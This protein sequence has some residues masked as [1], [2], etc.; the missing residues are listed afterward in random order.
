VLPVS[1]IAVCGY[2]KFVFDKARSPASMAYTIS[3]YDEGGRPLG[4]LGPYATIIEA[5]NAMIKHAGRE[6]DVGP[7]TESWVI[8]GT[9]Y[10]IETV[11]DPPN[12]CT[13][14][15]CTSLRQRAAM[16][17]DVDKLLLIKAADEIER[18]QACKQA[19]DD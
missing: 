17:T 19:K 9:E 14:R 6:P 2:A 3:V 18:L 7:F 11:D 12:D 4:E 16:K 8:G 13:A 5:R 15:L 10:D 1:G